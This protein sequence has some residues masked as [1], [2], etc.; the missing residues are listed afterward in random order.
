MEGLDKKP[1]SE[2]GEAET[3]FEKNGDPGI[4][5]TGGGSSSASNELVEGW[6]GMRILSR[7]LDIW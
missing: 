4:V 3:V 7:L 6:L 5:E 1:E 2:G